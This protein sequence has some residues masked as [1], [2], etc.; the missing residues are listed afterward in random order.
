MEFLFDT[1]N[2]EEIRKYV[3]I[4]PI[5]GVTSNPTIIKKE[6]KID[7]YNHFR[8]IRAIIGE[9][10]S[11]HIQL[12]APDEDTM[13]REA[14]AVLDRVDSKV[15]IKV[16]AN[17]EGFKVMR[18]LRKERVG[19]TATAVYSKIQGYLA[20]E[21]GADF[22]APYF[23][24]M[25]NLGIDSCDTISAL[26]RQIQNSGYETKILA[27]SFK[28]IAQVNAAFAAGAQTATLSPELLH[29]AMGMAAVVRAVEDFHK[30]WASIFGEKDL[31]Q[32]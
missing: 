29:E 20:L 11:L 15:F 21:A 25:E 27:A 5:T 6:G 4:Y 28:N 10:R 3:R 32:L 31:T 9:E 24:R 19:V 7:F 22:I 17:E 12:T 2:I 14:D 1:A 30:D 18:A 26:A 16:P 23:N 13:L 8:E